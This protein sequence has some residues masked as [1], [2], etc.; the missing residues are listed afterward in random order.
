MALAVMVSLA[1]TAI[2]LSLGDRVAAALDFR[3]LMLWPVSLT[4]FA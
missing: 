1:W 4:R 2:Q 3:L